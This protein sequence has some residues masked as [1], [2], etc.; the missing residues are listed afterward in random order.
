M[1]RQKHHP[2][3]QNQTDAITL[4]IFLYACETWTLTA[5]LQR[6]VQVMKIRCYQKILCISYKDHVTNKEVH[7]RI[8][9]ASGPYED[10][11]KTVKRQKRKWYGHVSRTS[12]MTTTILQGTVR[13]ARQRKRWEDNIK[14]WTGPDFSRDTKGGRREEE[15]ETAGFKVGGAPTTL[16]VTGL[17]M[18][19]IIMFWFRF[20]LLQS[21]KIHSF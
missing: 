13:G 14:E 10:L 19:I 7:N 3:I 16:R 2:L 11:L 15:V 17:M 8:K 5:K 12:G 21:C 18:M 9:Q 4:S 6:R 1:E 20:H